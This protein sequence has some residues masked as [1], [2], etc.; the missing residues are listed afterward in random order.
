MR[1]IETMQSEELSKMGL[2]RMDDQLSGLRNLS[3]DPNA[4]EQEV[5]QLLSDAES[6]VIADQEALAEALKLEQKL[7][8]RQMLELIK[9]QDA[10]KLTKAQQEENVKNL[11]KAEDELLAT[12]KEQQRELEESLAAEHEA[13]MKQLDADETHDSDPL[14]RL[15]EAHDESSLPLAESSTPAPRSRPPG[16]RLHSLMRARFVRARARASTRSPRRRQLR[17]PSSPRGSMWAVNRRSTVC[18]SATHV[19]TP[20]LRVRPTL[21]RRSRAS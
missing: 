15:S 7:Q 1:D 14:T 18:A 20:Q 9:T 17:E 16:S 8:E 12:Q 10:S 19:T 2:K 4:D 21:T 13:A 3:K 5:Q 6:A 11:V